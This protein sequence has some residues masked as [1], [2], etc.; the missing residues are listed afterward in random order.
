MTFNYQTTLLWSKIKNKLF[1]IT[2]GNCL[3]LWITICC[4]LYRKVVVSIP[5]PK[6]ELLWN[7]NEGNKPVCFYSKLPWIINYLLVLFKSWLRGSYNS[8][9][10]LKTYI[11]NRCLDLMNRLTL[12]TLGFVTWYRRPFNLHLDFW[13]SRSWEIKVLV[14]PQKNFRS[15]KPGFFFSLSPGFFSSL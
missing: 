15:C 10:R 4:F 2:F 8:L 7:L 6:R 12:F 14:K 1:L 13:K 3:L 9:K 11:W 5:C